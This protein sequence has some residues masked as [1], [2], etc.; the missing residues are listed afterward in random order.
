MI[1]NPSPCL[2]G[3]ETALWEQGIP[4]LVAMFHIDHHVRPQLLTP[5]RCFLT[6]VVIWSQVMDRYLGW[7][8]LVGWGCWLDETDET[9]TISD[10]KVP[11]KP[12]F[13]QNQDQKCHQY[14]TPK[15]PWKLEGKNPPENDE[16]LPSE[17]PKVMRRG[18]SPIRLDIP[19]LQDLA[20]NGRFWL[21]CWLFK[22]V[23]TKSTQIQMFLR[24]L[25]TSL[26]DSHECWWFQYT[27]IA[28]W[29]NLLSFLAP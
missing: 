13:T 20:P 15:L 1:T 26:T 2:L 27:K 16:K 14:W 3:S 9:P 28:K 19:K 4:Y 29:T 21:R 10:R 18:C 17:L 5:K 7:G 6:D 25:K 24:C 11:G 22:L 23:A 8:W 12:K